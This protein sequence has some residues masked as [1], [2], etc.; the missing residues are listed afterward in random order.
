MHADDVRRETGRVCQWD[1]FGEFASG[2][3]D[4]MATGHKLLYQRSEKRNV[5][6][7]CQIDPKTHGLLITSV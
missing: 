5:W 7:V 6:R 1:S 2:N 4:F 3:F